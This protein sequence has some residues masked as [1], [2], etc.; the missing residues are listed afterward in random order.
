LA[1]V[2]RA[3]SDTFVNAAPPSLLRGGVYVPFTSPLLMIARL[4]LDDDGRPTALVPALSGGQG[5][6]VVPWPMLPD[7]V[8][9]TIYDR[10]LHESLGGILHADPNFVRKKALDVR[11][12]GLCGPR[13]AVAAAEEFAND[14]RRR[15]NIFCFLVQ[16]IAAQAGRPIEGLNAANMRSPENLT[17]LRGLATGISVPP[18]ALIERLDA[19]SSQIGLLGLNQKE[20]RGPVRQQLADLRAMFDLMGEWASNDHPEYVGS[21]KRCLTAGE[22][23]LDLIQSQ[24]T[25]I[26]NECDD[27]LGIVANWTANAGLLK[28][29][30]NFAVTAVQIWHAA[31]VEWRSVAEER[32]RHAMRAKIGFIETLLP[33]L[34]PSDMLKFQRNR[35]T[36]DLM[37]GIAKP[38]RRRVKGRR[39]SAQEPDAG[40]REAIIAAE[41]PNE[42]L[43]HLLCWPFSNLIRQR[44]D[45][46]TP[47][48]LPLAAVTSLIRHLR[49]TWST[50]D[51]ARFDAVLATVDDPQTFGREVDQLR[52]TIHLMLAEWLAWHGGQRDARTPV[53][54][55]RSPDVP[56]L[57]DD[58]AYAAAMMISVA[59]VVALLSQLPRAPITWLTIDNMRH[60]GA[61]LEGLARSG[62]AVASVGALHLVM[63]ALAEPCD[64]VQTLRHL[65]AHHGPLVTDHPAMR[66]VV[67]ALVARLA[68]LRDDIGDA[69]TRFDGS[70]RLTQTI[71]RFVGAIG[72]G[73]MTLPIRQDGGVTA[74]VRQVIADVG[75]LV[76]TEVLEQLDRRVLAA[77]PACDDPFSNDEEG[78]IANVAEAL[79]QEELSCIE[80][81]LDLMQ[82]LRDLHRMFD[83]TNA[84]NAC[85]VSAG[86]A[87]ERVS[88]R[89]Q[90]AMLRMGTVHSEHLRSHVMSTVWLV[91]RLVGPEAADRLRKRTAQMISGSDG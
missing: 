35:A 11:R 25:R 78:K 77:F 63:R 80:Q 61:T 26:D 31:T 10:A 27:A 15:E 75:Q 48:D 90:Q 18:D 12:G 65:A 21:A 70:S 50:R 68:A 4:R 62:F 41:D 45:A 2:A 79:D 73:V 23:I 59:Q 36:Q 47:G 71:E 52:K 84:M 39:S 60:I 33:V 3:L 64:I 86:S 46:A 9:M 51:V 6:Y 17:A 19:W 37:K 20:L 88:S 5:Y 81:T 14:I 38:V 22:A 87:A 58:E 67:D 66:T 24:I 56:D 57:T 42:A 89:L 82:R 34:A 28:S 7:L 43:Q 74:K 91:E 32:D 85:K 44:G 55:K 1:V 54:I 69:A 13:A 16:R 8:N 49:K 30:S 76:R 72:T 53:E 29:I 40:L 83:L